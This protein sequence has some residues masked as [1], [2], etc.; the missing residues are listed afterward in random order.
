MTFFVNIDIH[1]HCHFRHPIPSLSIMSTN[2]GLTEKCLP[3]PLL[4]ASLAYSQTLAYSFSVTNSQSV[5]CKSHSASKVVD[6]PA[7]QRSNPVRRCRLH[8]TVWVLSSVNACT[9]VGEMALPVT[10][11]T[12]LWPFGRCPLPHSPRVV[13]VL[14]WP[15]ASLHNTHGWDGLI[16][17]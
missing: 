15:P 8:V 1:R 2:I 3:S 6:S 12:P 14:H 7:E 9:D 5:M 4:D 16:A 13:C 17:R 10:L 11:I